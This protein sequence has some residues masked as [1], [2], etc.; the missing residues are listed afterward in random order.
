MTISLSDLGY[1]SYFQNE[2]LKLGDTSFLPARVI[3]EHKGMYRVQNERGEFLGEISGKLRYTASSRENFPTVGDWVCIQEFD[4]EAKCIIHGILPRKTKLSR[5][6]PSKNIEEQILCANLDTIFIVQPMDSTFNVNRIERYL[7]IGWESGAIPIV[8]LSKKDLCETPDSILLEAEAVAIGTKVHAISSL[9]DDGLEIIKA[10]LKPGNTIAFIGQSGAG[11]STL[12]NK[13]SGKDLQKTKDIREA[14]SKG[15]HATTHRELFVLDNGLLID[16]PGLREIQLWGNDS[17][18]EET[19]SDIEEISS[20]CRFLDCS[21]ESE[22]GCAVL[23]AIEKGEIPEERFA[24][25][26]KMKR[27]LEYLKSKI[28]ESAKIQRK[29]KER[30]L[31]KT[32]REVLKKKYGNR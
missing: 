2:F 16:T 15:R 4:G 11:K 22:P 8:I 24:N 25:Y 30:Q 27:E 20:K 26:L 13:L 7:A 32:I 19:F 10:Y 3:S 14:D 21:H 23:A 17:M 18:L 31:H 12:I 9:Q 5:K 29:Q 28:N 6:S 1:N